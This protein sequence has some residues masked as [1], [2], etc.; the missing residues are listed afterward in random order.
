LCPPLDLRR[1]VRLLAPQDLH[2]RAKPQ[3]VQFVDG[4]RPMAA[5]RAPQPTNQPWTRPSG[6]VG[7]RSIHNLHEF[8]ITLRQTHADKD[9]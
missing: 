3:R 1:Q 8:P 4:E 5:L 9:T 6:R 7:Q 2:P